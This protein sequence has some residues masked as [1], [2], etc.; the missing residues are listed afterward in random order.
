[1]NLFSKKVALLSILLFSLTA[2]NAQLNTDSLRTVLKKEKSDSATFTRYIT[3][4]TSLSTSDIDASLLIGNWVA[5]NALK[6]KSYKFYTTSQIAIAQVYHMSSDFVLA[7]KYYVEAQSAAAKYGFYELELEAL[8]DLANVYF[9]NNQYEKAEEMYLKT[10]EGCKKYGIMEGVAVGYGSLGTIYY[11][12]YTDISKKQKGIEYLKMSMAVS[13]SMHDTIQLIRAYSNISTMYRKLNRLDSALYWV[14]KS[15]DMMRA[16][17]NNYEGYLYHYYHK[18]LILSAMQDYPAAIACYLEGV[19]YTKKLSSPMWE[20]S[21]YDGLY[22]AYKAIGDEKKALEYFEKYFHIEDS[23]I[24]TENFAKAADVQNKYEREKKE[25]EIIRLNKDNEISALLLDKE[26]QTKRNLII[27]VISAVFILLSLTVLTIFLVRTIRE[28]KKAYT[29]LE[30]KNM[31]IRAQGEQLNKQSKLIAR[32]Q[33]QMNPHFIFNA[34]NN[35]Q[36]FVIESEK[37]K[38]IHQLQSFSTL[39]RQTLNNSESETIPLDKELGFLRTYLAFE[40]ERFANKIAVEIKCEGDA[41]EFLIPPMMIQPFLENA[42]KHGGLQHVPG[43]S[44]SL[45]IKPGNG[46]LQIAISDNG[47]GIDPNKTDVIKNSHAVFIIRSRIQLLFQSANMELPS[48][49]FEIIPNSAA[50]RGTTVRF[51]LP[52]LYNY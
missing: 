34:L 35:I 38:A 25:K 20:S 48:N 36:G 31:E 42:F 9:L 41:D 10:V 24:T 29:R 26:M 7:T 16:K 23:L 12:G 43:A 14:E 13:E 44:I 4:M 5:E 33:S 21:H 52:L 19:A 1:M 6:A 8:N 49:Y 15:G 47:A 40:Q 17:Q 22:K 11:N 27:T 32:Y 18:G 30:E 50:G 51:Y 46:L 39:M 37:E 2:V 28:R 45:H 3:L